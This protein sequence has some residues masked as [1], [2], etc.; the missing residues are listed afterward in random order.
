MISRTK[1]KQKCVNEEVQDDQERWTDKEW[2]KK[3]KRTQVLL[4]V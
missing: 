1:V 2:K 3:M 4:P